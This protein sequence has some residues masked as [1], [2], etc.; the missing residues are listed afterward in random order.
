MIAGVKG[1]SARYRFSGMPGECPRP[2]PNPTLPPRPRTPHTHP[3]RNLTPP[4]HQTLTDTGQGNPTDNLDFFSYNAGPIHVISLAS[5]FPSFTA[6]SSMT[7][8]LKADLAKVDRSVTPWI[9]VRAATS[10]TA[11]RAR[12]HAHWSLRA[13]L[14]RSQRA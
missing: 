11:P 4:A 12:A 7:V 14:V 5:F 8:W 3:N 13:Q 2:T 10:R 6:T 1:A 9:V